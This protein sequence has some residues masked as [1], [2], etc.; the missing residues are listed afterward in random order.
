MRRLLV[1]PTAQ[2]RFDEFYVPRSK[3]E[4]TIPGWP[5]RQ[6][7][8]IMLY[9]LPVASVHGDELILKGAQIA[10]PEPFRMTTRA[11][12]DMDY[13]GIRKGCEMER[14][15]PITREEIMGIG[16]EDALWELDVG[17]EFHLG[18]F[19]IIERAQPIW[20]TAQRPQRKVRLCDTS[21]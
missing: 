9:A 16:S 20:Q 17:S 7:F 2:Q 4:I 15:C 1:E 8:G 18:D 19:E 10:L 12:R 14:A 6:R 21:G 13:F 5:R 11:W 3:V